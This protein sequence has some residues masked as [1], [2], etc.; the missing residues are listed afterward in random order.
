M[1]YC[2]FQTGVILVKPSQIKYFLKK[3]LNYF[4]FPAVTGKQADIYLYAIP[5]FRKDMLTFSASREY[6]E[7]EYISTSKATIPIFLVL[8]LQC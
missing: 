7:K 6:D 3:L 8:H 4:A 1:I 5:I 2:I